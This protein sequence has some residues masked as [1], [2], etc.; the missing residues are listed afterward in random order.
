LASAGGTA[1][2]IRSISPLRSARAS[3]LT[4]G[5]TRKTTSSAVGL[6]PS[7]SGYESTRLSTYRWP[8]STVCS[9]YGPAETQLASLAN[10]CTLGA[11]SKTCLGTTGIQK[12]TLS[13][14]VPSG[15]DRWNSISVGDTAVAS[16]YEGIRPATTPIFSLAT[17][18]IVKI[19]S[20]AVTFVPSLQV[21][22]SRSVTLA[23]LPPSAYS[24]LVAR[25]GVRLPSM[26][27]DIRRGYMRLVTQVS[28]RLLPTSGL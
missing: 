20:S 22:S 9:L 25:Y 16:V 21:K 23:V 6:P 12:P 27:M 8:R 26:S 3:V 18:S 19:T 13:R 28:V 11:F 10:F 7:T 17:A 14:N 1:L 24:H 5:K 4:S 15:C 2:A